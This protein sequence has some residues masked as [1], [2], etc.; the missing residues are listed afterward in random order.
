MTWLLKAIGWLE[1]LFMGNEEPRTRKTIST[2]SHLKNVQSFVADFAEAAVAAEETYGLPAE[3]MLAQAALETG[4]GQRILR[5]KAPESDTTVS[6]NNLFNIKKG[7]PF[8]WECHD[9]HYSMIP[10][11]HYSMCVQW[12]RICLKAYDLNKL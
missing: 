6:S 9:C 1:R 5:G 11:I 4:W 12:A 7:Q 3:G 8:I 2:H 10:I